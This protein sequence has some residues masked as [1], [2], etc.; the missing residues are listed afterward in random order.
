MKTETAHI[1]D[2]LTK[3]DYKRQLQ[4]EFTLC[5][6]QE[7]KTIM[8]A[9]FHMLETGTNF[10]GTMSVVCRECKVNDD[11]NHRLNYCKK[12][13]SI[14]LYNETQKVDFNHI[15]SN[16][17]EVVRSINEPIEKVWNTRNANGT[18]NL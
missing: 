16:D 10:K 4:K 7:T 5:T 6:R 1:V 17:I 9:R 3:Q 15:Y 2:Q 12:Y 11:E 8:I 14:N 18:M 13:Q